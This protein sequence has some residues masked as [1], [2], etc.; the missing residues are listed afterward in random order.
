VLTATNKRL[1]I[2][3]SRGDS[4]RY[5]HCRGKPDQHTTRF[6]RSVRVWSMTI[7]I[8]Q[9]P[10][11]A[12]FHT[13]INRFEQIQCTCEEELSTQST[14]R[15]LTDPRVHTQLLPTTANGAV[16]KS[17][18]SVDNR[19]L[20]LPGPYHRHPI[21]TFNTC[22]RGLTYRFLTDTGGG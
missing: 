14:T 12:T 7:R 11:I 9:G 10:H 3:E 2:S 6:P 4:N 21:S 1:L 5:T 22:S 8:S 20:G 19:L 15:W 18:V 17:Q 13:V 16:E